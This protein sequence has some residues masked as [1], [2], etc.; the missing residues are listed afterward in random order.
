MSYKT[1]LFI[2]LGL[3]FLYGLFTV[4]FP[5]L[6][7][8]VVAIAI[9][10]MNQLFMKWF[11]FNRIV[12]ATITSTL[13]ILFILAVMFLIGLKIISEMSVLIQRFPTYIRQLSDYVQYDLMD[14]AQVLIEQ[15]SPEEE[16]QLLEFIQQSTDQLASTVSKLADV[17]VSQAGSLA[18]VLSNLFIF[19]IVFAVAV[20]LF[21][22][23]LPLLKKSFLSMF[24]EESQDKVDK[25][26]QDLRFSI[27]GFMKAQLILSSLTY[28]LSLIGLLILDVNFAMAVALL[29]VIVDIL[30]ILGTGSFIVPWA[31]YNLVIGDVY[32][33]VG[34]F[35]L[36][37]ALTVFRRVVEPK[38][39]GDSVG[40][41][42]L[43]AL[44]SLYVG[45]KLVGVVGLFLGP[46]VVIVY[47][48]MRKVGLLQIKI[49][50]E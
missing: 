42:A 21:S 16:R 38:I 1:L 39:L 14:K 17:V 44:I 29:I 10:P 13:F 2:V 9:E 31:V 19:F 27:F 6:L 22:Y 4:G 33:A 30:P 50:L 45:F 3:A 11:R 40:I 36:F 34:L 35:I 7:A 25:V 5:F 18:G 41:G 37:I 46:I 24:A 26:L 12:A 15:L 49:R 32:L 8:I 43:S 20:F 23:S 47:T 28:I 48:A